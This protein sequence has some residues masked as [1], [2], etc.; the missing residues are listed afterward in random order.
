MASWGRPAPELLTPAN[1]LTPFLESSLPVPR[2][3][4]CESAQHRVRFGYA[5]Q[6]TVGTGEE[7]SAQLSDS[8]TWL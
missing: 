4:A 5:S 8:A 2:Y 7:L 3:V 6:A 1:S